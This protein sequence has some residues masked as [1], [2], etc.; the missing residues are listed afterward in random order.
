MAADIL[1][2]ITHAPEICVQRQH[3]VWAQPNDWRGCGV[4][5]NRI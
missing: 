3:E 2:S 1:A 5:H 4:G